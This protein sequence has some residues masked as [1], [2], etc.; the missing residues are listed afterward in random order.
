MRAVD[1]SILAVL[2]TDAT[3]ETNYFKLLNHLN[4]HLA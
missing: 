1:W 3:P 4:F 2:F